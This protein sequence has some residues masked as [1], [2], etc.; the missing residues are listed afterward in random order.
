MDYKLLLLFLSM[1]HLTSIPFSWSSFFKSFRKATVAQKNVMIKIISLSGEISG[2]QPFCKNI[3]EAYKDPRIDGILL[4]INS[5]GG[6][7][8]ASDTLFRLIKNIAQTKPV[9]VYV[10]STCCSGAYLAAIGANKIVAP[11]MANIGSIGV[12]KEVERWHDIQVKRSGYSAQTDIELFSAGAEKAISW[13]TSKPLNEEIRARIQHH[14]NKIY[15]VFCKKVI[16]N[17]PVDPAQRDLWANGKVVIGLEAFD[18]GLIDIV[19][20]YCEAVAELKRLIE[21]RQ[22]KHY[23]DVIFLA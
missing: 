6:D 7:S 23:D 19:G 13:P 1:T 17:R 18:L 21:E 5:G 3:Y 20:S 9:V 15:D 11:E 2:T 4:L 22:K 16:E 14:L 8:G 12:I 10:E